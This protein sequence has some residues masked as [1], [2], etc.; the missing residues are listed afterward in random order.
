[1]LS[2]CNLWQVCHNYCNNITTLW[3]H[4]AITLSC[5]SH[6]V[7]NMTI[8]A[9]YYDNNTFFL[10]KLRNLLFQM[11]KSKE[12]NGSRFWQ[13]SKSNKRWI[14]CSESEPH[15]VKDPDSI[16]PLLYLAPWGFR[17]RVCMWG[18]G[19]VHICKIHKSSRNFHKNVDFLDV[20]MGKCVISWFA[21]TVLRH[22]NYDFTYELTRNYESL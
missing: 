18:G 9:C 14:S 10:W 17:H 22:R 4:S 20:I 15:R 19:V 3:K 13:F 16:P 8:L 2:C 12:R 21:C 7:M 5:F 11:W 1:M 6:N